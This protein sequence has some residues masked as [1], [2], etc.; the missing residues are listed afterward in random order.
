MIGGPVKSTLAK[1]AA[2]ATAGMATIL[3]TVRMAFA[4]STGTSLPPEYTDIL[5]LAQQK[6]QAATQ[7][8]AIGNG[9][10]MLYGADPMTLLPWV[11]LAAAVAIGA[12]CAAKLLAPRMRNDALIVQQ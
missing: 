7:P 9:V 4:A 5:G 1:I 2:A 12:V 8:E 10:P 3:S 6:V 11:G